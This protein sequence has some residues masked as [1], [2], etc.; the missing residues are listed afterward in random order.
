MVFDCIG[1]IFGWSLRLSHNIFH[2]YL[3]ALFVFLVISRILY[4]VWEVIQNKRSA[5]Y[6]LCAKMIDKCQ[7]EVAPHNPNAFVACGEKIY[8]A[9]K[10]SAFTGISN[11]ITSFLILTVFL[12]ALISPITYY[13]RA[14]PTDVT[15][16]TT[17]SQIEIFEM[18]N[19]ER[20]GSGDL[21]QEMQNEKITVAGHSVFASVTMT[22]WTA[23]FPF[24]ILLLQ[25]AGIIGGIKTACDKENSTKKRIFAVLIPVIVM[26]MMVTSVFVLPLYIALE[27]VI[28][29]IGSILF[30]IIFRKLI[31]PRYKPVLDTMN[32]QCLAIIEEE[33]NKIQAD[34]VTNGEVQNG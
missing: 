3:L 23:C 33:K 31:A 8:K 24:I 14:K 1:W 20:L 2:N 18:E 12:H 21:A 27:F 22:D 30:V 29:R 32:T 6:A 9:T 11:G 19:T 5:R 16:D 17:L 25:A 34:T 4:T 13:F 26:V 7:K 10:T 15:T 28:F